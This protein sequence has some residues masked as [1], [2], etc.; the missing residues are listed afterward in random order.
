MALGGG[1]FV[2]QN[3]K[4]PGTYI[5]FISASKATSA[6]SDRGVAALA[7]ELDWGA[8]NEIIEMTSGDFNKN[9]LK[10]LGYDYANDKLKGLRDLFLNIRKVYLYRLNGGGNKATATIPAGQSQTGITATAKYS[11]TRGNNI[12]IVVQKNID[13]DSKWDVITLLDTK[14]VDKQTV[15]ASSGLVDNDYVTFTKTGTLAAT[16]GTALTG[17]TNGTVTGESHQ[18][19]LDKLEGYSFNALGCISTESSITSLYVTFTKR[20]RDEMGIK[21]QTVLYNNAA[22]YEGIVNVKNRTTESDTGLVYWV[23]GVIAGCAINKS[24][25]NKVYDGEF[26]VEATDTQ[27]ELENAIDSGKF[28]LHKVGDDIRVLKD[29]NSLV[30]TDAEKGADFKNNQTIRVIDQLAIDVASI[31]NTKYIGNIPNNESGRVSLWSDIVAIYNGYLQIQAIENFNADEITV[32]QGDDKESVVVNGSIQP[33]NA[34]T[35][36]YTTIIVE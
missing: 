23:T 21:F 30:T 27:S 6:I 35:K 22:D 7:V 17:G 14:Q 24:N 29:I 20:L 1:N 15:A 28:T 2:A 9:T 3:K 16:T 13:D 19:F 18:S 36:L 26:T 12:R 34:M 4:L 31:F 8:D 33:V 25:T 32:E 10:T 5:N 11:G